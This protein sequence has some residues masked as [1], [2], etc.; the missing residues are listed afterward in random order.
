MKA[1]AAQLAQGLYLAVRE[2]PGKRREIVARFFTFLR[3][4]RVAK[5]LPRVVKRLDQVEQESLNFKKVTIESPLI[6]SSKILDNIKK[7]LTEKY[8]SKKIIFDQKI[9]KNLLGGVRISFNDTVIDATAQSRLKQ[10][11]AKI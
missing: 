3:R 8:H 1:G 4:K 7:V 5:L 2:N 9:N 11:I 6:L 10:L